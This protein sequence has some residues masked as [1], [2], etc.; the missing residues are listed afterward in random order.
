MGMLFPK[1]LIKLFEEDDKKTLE[2]WKK[3]NE[4]R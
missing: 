2:K 3:E 4:Q 1:N